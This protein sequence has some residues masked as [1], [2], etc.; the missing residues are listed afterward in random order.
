[1]FARRSGSSRCKELRTFAVVRASN[2]SGMV[3]DGDFSQLSVV[4]LLEPLEIAQS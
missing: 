4:R 3:E 1:M 2:D